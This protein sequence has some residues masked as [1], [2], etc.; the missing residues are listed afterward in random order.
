MGLVLVIDV[1]AD[2]LKPGGEAV[3][4]SVILQDKEIDNLIIVVD[5][6][7]HRTNIGTLKRLIGQK[8]YC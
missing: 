8:F 4:I 2:F 5:D 7:C 1:K 6:D 3:V